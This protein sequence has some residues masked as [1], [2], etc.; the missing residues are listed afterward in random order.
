MTAPL[1]F[2]TVVFEPELPLLR[3]QARSLARYLDPDCVAAI[4]VLDNCAGGMGRHARRAVLARFGPVLAPRVSFVRTAQ[5]GMVGSTDGWRSQQAAKLL[6]ARRITTPHYVIL[7][8]KNHLIGPAGADD[9]VD[10]A[11]TAR[12]GTH[13]YAAH[14]LREGLERTLRYL[15]ADDDTVERMIA[16]FP[17]TVTPFVADT[18]LARRMMDD[19]EA[20]ARES[21][22]DAFERAGLLEFFL[23][24]GWSLL[25]GPGSPVN[26]DTIPAPILWP[27]RATEDGAADAI[28]EAT[29]SGAAWFAVHRRALARA[30]APTRRRIARLW[31]DRGLMSPAE[32]A[33]FVRRFR[34]AYAP[35]TARARV[36]R[37]LSR[38]GHR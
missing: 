20:E 37:R 26:G 11:G 18:E 6:V 19:I 28:R 32:A 34:L 7:D 10:A 5:L 23:Y 2:V 4:I 15:G 9:F 1:T 24:S 17:R 30:D 16:D 33:R 25:R 36:G 22:G 31:S 35:A 8:A 3:L 38:L 14:P 27:A 13:S 12:G 29:E 21:F